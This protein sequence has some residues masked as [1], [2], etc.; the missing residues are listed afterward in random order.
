MI[1]HRR[2]IFVGLI[3]SLLLVIVGCATAVKKDDIEQRTSFALGLD[4][5]QFTISDVTLIGQRTNY[6]VQTTN[7]ETYRCYVVGITTFQS[8]ISDAICSQSNVGLDSK[9]SAKGVSCNALLKA[10][11]KC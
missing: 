11:G 4:R 8:I 1:I 5:N 6:S 2:Y 10:T 9:K 3:I 7:G